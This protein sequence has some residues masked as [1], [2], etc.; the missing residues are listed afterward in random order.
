MDVLVQILASALAALPSALGNMVAVLCAAL[1]SVVAVSFFRGERTDF[2]TLYLVIIFLTGTFNPFWA[3]SEAPPPCSWL[4]EVVRR[5]RGS[6]PCS[7]RFCCCVSFTY[8]D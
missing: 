4:T 6:W 7:S 8:S 1:V 3:S 2:K 5:T